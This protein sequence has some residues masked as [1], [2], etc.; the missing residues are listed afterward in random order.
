MSAKAHAIRADRGTGSAKPARAVSWQR[1]PSPWPALARK[2]PYR[3]PGFWKGEA[4]GLV[5]AAAA[6]AIRLA[7]TPWVGNAIPVVLFYPFVLIAAVWGGTLSG[8]T[9]LVICGGAASVLWL[10]PD[11]RPLT[12]TAF[13]IACFSVIVMARLFR[14]LVQ[15]HVEDEERAVLLSHEMAHRVGNLFGVVQ[16]ISAQTARHATSL[17][18][19]QRLFSGRLMALARTQRLLAENSQGQTELKSFIDEI[20][21]PFGGARFVVEG[22]SV[23]VPR[24]L[25][26]SCA[27]LLHELCTNA[28]KY[29]S[30]SVPDGRVRIAWRIQDNRARLEWREYNG[31]PVTSPARNGFGSRLLKTAF[32][33]NH[34]H[35]EI[36]YD[37]D[38][39]KCSLEFA[40]L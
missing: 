1:P 2:V 30:L 39:V 36:R 24:Y 31:P 13:S 37:P 21:E 4:I 26:T 3:P 32:S 28:L 20:V 11:G 35:A 14:A 18:D 38:G 9:V 22:P 40:L 7:L 29:G 5:C 8:L 15:V 25:G 6:L 33:P 17:A 16:A 23:A 27:L 19:H 34:G 10:Q 12:L